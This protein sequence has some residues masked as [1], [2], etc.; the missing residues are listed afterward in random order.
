MK[1]DHSRWGKRLALARRVA[2]QEIRHSKDIV[3]QATA[4][5]NAAID[6]PATAA[7]RTFSAINLR[8]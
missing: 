6:M 7:G 8:P 2:G 1:E 4:A 3:P 5:P